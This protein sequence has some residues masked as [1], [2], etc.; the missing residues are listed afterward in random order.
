MRALTGFPE[1]LGHDFPLQGLVRDFYAA[2][3]SREGYGA[4]E[5]QEVA[6]KVFDLSVNMGGKA[7]HLCLQRACRACGW[8]LNEDGKL[9]PKTLNAANLAGPCLLVALRSEAAGWYRD[10]DRKEFEN[11]WVERAYS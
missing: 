1:S 9:G 2:W 11:A 8:R 6:T 3:W 4:I 5:Q 10:L 7:A